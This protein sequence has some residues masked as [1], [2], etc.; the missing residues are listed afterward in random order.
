MTWLLTGGAGY[1]G[2]HIL[3]ALQDIGKEV[4]VLDDLS[5]GFAENVPAGVE[6]VRANVLDT[7]AVEAALRT[8]Q[9]SA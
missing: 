2:A 8:H 3:R 5:N 1:I 4:V 9:V 7:A 6:L